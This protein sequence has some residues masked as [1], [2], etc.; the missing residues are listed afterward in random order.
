MWRGFDSSVVYE[1]NAISTPGTT[2]WEC[3]EHNQPLMP[4]CD[5]NGNIYNNWIGITCGDFDPETGLVNASYS[6]SYCNNIVMIE[7]NAMGNS[8]Q[9]TISPHIGDFPYLYTLSITS[10]PLKGTIPSSIGNLKYLNELN[11]FD[12]IG[13]LGVSLGISGTIP[14]SI[15]QLINLQYFRLNDNSLAGSIPPTMCHM[16]SILDLHFTNNFLRGNVPAC[17]C[18]LTSMTALNLMYNYLACYPD[19]VLNAPA[20]GSVLPVALPTDIIPSACSFCQNN[21]TYASITGPLLTK[22]YSY[23]MLGAVTHYCSGNVNL[24]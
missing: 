1:A 18:S 20:Y 16:Q 3:D 8:L 10:A 23:K 21:V 22:P 6:L 17:L 4:Y 9:G 24:D 2:T 11:I 7:L 13:N 15:D 19:C 5:P 12:T 14:S